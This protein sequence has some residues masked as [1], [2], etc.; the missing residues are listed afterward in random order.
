MS[1]VKKIAVTTAGV[2]IC[3]YALRQIQFTRSLVDKALV[4]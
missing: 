3:V 1:Q 4:G 2:L